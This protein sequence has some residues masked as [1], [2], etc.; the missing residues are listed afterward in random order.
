[1]ILHWAP[2]V[3]FPSLEQE[4]DRVVN[5]SGTLRPVHDL[6]FPT[7]EGSRT[8]NHRGGFW[9][10]TPA[11]HTRFRAPG[12]RL[13]SFRHSAE[14]SRLRQFCAYHEP[15][16][17]SWSDMAFRQV[18]DTSHRCQSLLSRLTPC[19]LLLSCA[20]SPFKAWVAGSNPAALTTHSAPEV[21]S[22]RQLPPVV[23]FSNLLRG[24]RP[25]YH[26]LCPLR[27]LLTT[28]PTA[29]G[30]VTTSTFP[31]AWC[32]RTVITLGWRKAGERS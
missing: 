7:Q 2:V 8:Q 23:Y 1:M 6:G 15:D 21:T 30:S 16:G 11:P 26:G 28:H 10:P 12:E 14:A 13:P 18:L 29:A 24:R 17:V 19:N 31:S 25:S 20:V 27:R 22:P 32:S 5:S 9:G 3:E 4:G